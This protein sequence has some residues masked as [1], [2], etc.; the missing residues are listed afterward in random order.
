MEKLSLWVAQPP[1]FSRPR[2][3]PAAA[4]VFAFSNPNKDA[5]LLPER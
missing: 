2:A 5:T 1:A 3:L 4:G